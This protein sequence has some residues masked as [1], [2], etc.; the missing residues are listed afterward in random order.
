MKIIEFVKRNIS[1]FTFVTFCLLLMVCIGFLYLKKDNP[2]NSSI[3]GIYII[4]MVIA[5]LFLLFDYLTK[6]CIYSRLRLNLFQL[7]ILLTL[8]I[9]IY[10]QYFQLCQD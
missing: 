2:W 9:L 1:V 5:F 10:Y 8:S 3:V 7:F 4:G 6:K